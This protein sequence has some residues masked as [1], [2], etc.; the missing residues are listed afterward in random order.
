[1]PV[2]LV[3]TVRECELPVGINSTCKPENSI[4]FSL[5]YLTEDVATLVYIIVV[6]RDQERK[7]GP[8]GF[9]DSTKLSHTF[10]VKKDQQKTK[11]LPERS[12][13][14]VVKMSE[15][16][17]KDKKDHDQKIKVIEVKLIIKQG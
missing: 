7:V 17:E 2:C 11:G 8:D 1:M 12:R 15:Q 13:P 9:L 4:Y 6:F 3:F 10:Y 5:L 14:S 16:V